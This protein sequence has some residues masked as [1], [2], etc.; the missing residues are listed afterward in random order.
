MNDRGQESPKGK[1]GSNR[2]SS[3]NGDY[4]R[5]I[6]ER[7]KKYEPKQSHPEKPRE[8]ENRRLDQAHPHSQHDQHVHDEDSDSCSCVTCNTCH[9]SDCS[10]SEMSS[11]SHSSRCFGPIIVGFGEK[12]SNFQVLPFFRW[13]CGDSCWPGC[14]CSDCLSQC[15][16]F[17][18][19]DIRA[20]EKE[21]GA[22]LNRKHSDIYIVNGSD[23]SKA[24]SKAS[25]KIS[26]KSS[27]YDPL[28]QVIDSLTDSLITFSIC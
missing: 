14:E 22:R 28:P 15:W 12:F 6:G 24:S 9:L 1:K 16:P 3:K 18:S 2:P 23:V 13:F 19:Q 8:P 25:T 7:E 17:P 11:A 27:N 20:R 4:P 26:K 10:C 5:N 21:L